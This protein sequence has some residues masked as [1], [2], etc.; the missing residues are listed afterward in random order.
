MLTAT[1]DEIKRIAKLIR[2]NEN[3][4]HQLYK[5][6]QGLLEPYND[7]FTKLSND[8]VLL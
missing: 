6:I 2:E 3:E 8:E 7:D 5:K 4:V 1:T